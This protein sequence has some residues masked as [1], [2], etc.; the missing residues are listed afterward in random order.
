M[1]PETLSTESASIRTGPTSRWKRIWQDLF[2][3]LFTALLFTQLVATLVSVDGA[4]M[5]TSLRNGERIV[6]PKYE[7]W[8][9]KA[10]IGQFSRDDVQRSRLDPTKRAG[11][12]MRSSV[13]NRAAL[14]K[15]SVRSAQET[16]R[17]RRSR[18]GL[19]LRRWRADASDLGGFR[20]PRPAGERLLPLP[21]SAGRSNRTLPRG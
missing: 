6:V 3:P 17:N 12:L 21:G 14:T 20:S 1:R 8:L 18:R 13:V 11:V 15:T 7:T 4:S 9:H 19:R 2:Q 10:G 16:A 5:M